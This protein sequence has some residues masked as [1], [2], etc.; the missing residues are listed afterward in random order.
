MNHKVAVILPVYKKDKVE[1]ISKA[2]ESVV[3]QTYRDFHIYIGVD[4]PVADDIKNFIRTLETQKGLNA[5]TKRNLEADIYKMMKERCYNC[6]YTQYKDYGGRGIYVCSEWLNNYLNFKEWALNN[7]YDDNLTL[8]RIDVND[9]YKPSNCRWATR[10]EQA[11]NKR[12]TKN[13]YGVWNI[14]EEI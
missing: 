4:G 6:N 13:Q 5:S 7:G 10:K 8:D 12:Y 3:L 11:N 2:I 9:I 1:Y 14:K